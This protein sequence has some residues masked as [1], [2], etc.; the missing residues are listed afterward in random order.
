VKNLQGLLL[1]VAIAC[2][3]QAHLGAH[4][5]GLVKLGVAVQ[6]P[7]V[8]IELDSPLDNLLGFEHRPRTAAERQAARA[9]LKQMQ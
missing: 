8:S 6:G 2:A 7:T 9:L 1:L 4:V 3:A 5:H